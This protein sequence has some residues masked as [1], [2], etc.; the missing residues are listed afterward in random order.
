MVVEKSAL[1]PHATF[2]FAF[3]EAC[4]RFKLRRA[5]R[6]VVPTQSRRAAGA[7]CQRE[8][9]ARQREPSQIIP[10]LRL[11]CERTRLR[12]CLHRPAGTHQVT[13]IRQC[14]RTRASP[15]IPQ[16][17]STGPSS[18]SS[19][20]G[21]TRLA[22]YNH[23]HKP[24]RDGQPTNPPRSIGRRSMPRGP[25]ISSA[26]ATVR[27]SAS[28]SEQARAPS[29]PATARCTGRPRDKPATG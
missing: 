25:V 18:M 1:K 26:G 22:D 11:R 24:P 27:R 23:A 4:E 21:A 7:P 16:M 3:G 5:R 29:D 6:V 8:R 14:G 13:P 2:V 19:H 28:L 9:E 10:A 15:A 12:S 20:A 17:S